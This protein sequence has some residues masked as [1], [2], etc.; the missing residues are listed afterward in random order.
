MRDKI[1]EK[2]IKT[3][4]RRQKNV[5]NLVASENYVSSDVMR[6]LGSALTNKY[7]EGYPGKRFYAGNE[8]IDEI[9]IICQERALKLFGLSAKKWRVNVQA[10]SGSPANL[11]IF[12]ALVPLGA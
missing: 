1:I 7:S 3:E 4:T 9:E 12:A 8:V 10:H 6:A 11:A 2:L 5:L